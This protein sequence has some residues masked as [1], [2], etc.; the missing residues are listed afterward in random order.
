MCHD[1]VPTG[2]QNGGPAR[3]QTS[4]APR[5]H[6]QAAPVG[7]ER[8][9][10]PHAHESS[11][12]IRVRNA[13]G[14]APSFDPHREGLTVCVALASGGPLPQPLWSNRVTRDAS[15]LKKRLNRARSRSVGRHEERRPARRSDFRTTPGRCACRH[16]HPASAPR[17]SQ[18]QDKQRHI[19]TSLATCYPRS[20]R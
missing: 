11:R 7:L 18:S 8:R 20:G 14:T 3:L 19:S 9:K 4:A 6:V 17:M 5:P 1:P 13:I 12:A 16:R 15:R 10:E 2:W